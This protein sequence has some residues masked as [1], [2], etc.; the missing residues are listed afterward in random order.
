M[1]WFTKGKR[2]TQAYDYIRD[3]INSSSP[4]ENKNLHPWAQSSAEAEQI[5]SKL[6]LENQIIM[7]PMMGSG[8][9]GNAAAE[10]AA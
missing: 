4:N 10:I 3:F 6:T 1:L 5:I 8:T 7:D 9:T 2:N